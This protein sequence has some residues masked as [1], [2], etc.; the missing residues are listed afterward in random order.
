M[1]DIIVQITNLWTFPWRYVDVSDAR[2]FFCY[3]TPPVQ[4]VVYI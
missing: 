1:G 3:E 2:H 4:K